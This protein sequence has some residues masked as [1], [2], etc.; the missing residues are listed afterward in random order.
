MASITVDQLVNMPFGYLNGDD[1][2]EY[3]AYQLLI[4][5]YEI[6]KNSIQKGC[7][8]AYSELISLLN[9]RYNLTQEFA[10]RGFTN[11]TATAVVAGGSVTAINV[12]YSGSNY[13]SIPLITIGGPGSGATAQINVIDQAVSSIDVIN[14]GSGYTTAPIITLDGGAAADPRT[15][16]FVK[17]ASICAVRNALGNQIN[18]GEKM[19]EDFKWADKTILALRNA[20]QGMPTVGQSNPVTYGSPAEIVPSSF[21]T[22]G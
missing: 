8:I 12:T 21:L 20:Q 2:T 10:K 1:L 3:C 17:L 9:T 11:A 16:M 5:Q 13:G 6:K 14:G 15:L 19:A 4:K 22:L 18:I 7:D